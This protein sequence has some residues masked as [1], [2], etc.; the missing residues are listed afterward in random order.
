MGNLFLKAT[1]TVTRQKL[2][3]I[4]FLVFLFSTF[5][6][7]SDEIKNRDPAEHSEKPKNVVIKYDPEDKELSEFIPLKSISYEIVEQFC[8][9]MLSENGR[10]GY[11]PERSCVVVHDHKKNAAKI[12]EFIESANGQ[13]PDS[14]LNIRIDV[15]FR[16]ASKK[17]GSGVGASLDYP[18]KN[19]KGIVIK[20]G[21]IEKPDKISIGAFDNSETSRSDTSQFIVTRSG[22]P[23]RLWVGKRIVDPSWLRNCRFI[24]LT[25]ISKGTTSIVIPG[26]DPEI[27]WSDVGTYLYVL[28]RYLG[29]GLI[30]LEVFPAISYVDGKG[31]DKAVRIENVSTRLTLKSGQKMDLG[32]IVS[33]K[34]DT[35]RKL[36]G[37]S[38]IG[39]DENSSLLDM[40][41]KA[42]VIAPALQ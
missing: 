34:N 21:K 12:R 32:G 28:P 10:M 9:P 18:E 5:S 36:F 35:Y 6:L 41:V 15:Q 1:M 25:I 31:R 29:D 8:K 14:D 39:S 24:P 30:D 22:F 42:T 33:G 11:M 19:Q 38:F 3:L 16:G 27:V 4:F 26:N 20:N 7:R 13:M 2:H 40:S 23:A 17:A 37:P